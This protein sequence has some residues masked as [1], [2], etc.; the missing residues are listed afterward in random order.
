[1]IDSVKDVRVVKSAAADAAT[2]SSSV[3]LCR[4]TAGRGD[5][6]TVGPK[7]SDTIKIDVSFF[8]SDKK[9]EMYRLRQAVGEYGA[10]HVELVPC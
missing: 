10:R 3:A 1:M 5:R 2:I 9:V 6:G 8:A 4:S 7:V